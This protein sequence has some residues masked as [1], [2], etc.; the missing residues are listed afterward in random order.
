LGGFDDR[1]SPAYYEDADLAFGARSLGFRVVYQPMCEVIHSEGASHGTDLSGGVKRFQ[2]INRAKFCEK[3]SK[4]LAAEQCSPGQDPVEASDRR[5]HK[6][7]LVVDELVPEPDK[8][9]GSCR[10]RQILDLLTKLGFAVVFLPNNLQSKQPY[11]RDLQERGIEVLHS[12]INI[13]YKLKSLGPHLRMCLLSRPLV[14]WRY[15]H[16]LRVS[17]PRA[18]IV[19]DTVDLHYVREH[20]RALLENDPAVAKVAD[21]F[22][23]L[24]LAL[25]RA[26]DA[27]IA[28]TDTERAIIESEVPGARVFTIPMIHQVVSESPSFHE[29]DGLV[30][31]GNF[32]HLP[33]IDSVE[34]LVHEILPLIHKELPGLVLHLVGSFMPQSVKDL[35]SPSVK[36]AGWIPDLARYLGHRRVF[37]S[38]LRYGAGMK[39]KIGQSM[40]MGLPVVSTVMG[41]E[42]MPVVS[43]EQV[44]VAEGTER[45]AEA[46]VR[47]YRDEALWNAISANGKAYIAQTLSP[48]VV[49]RSVRQLLEALH[50]WPSELVG[51]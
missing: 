44:L 3:W 12:P 21:T 11:T 23:E 37:V 7:I 47:I 36:V 43:G 6:R 5:R 4:T 9:A 8:D 42:G 35:A 39:G 28:V 25:V 14:S 34:Y 18:A 27:T 15:L 13:E 10:M 46:T 45:F 51:D 48:E 30:F 22:R 24:E 26:S 1:Y 32:N 31:V 40:A 19:Y 50:V 17:A 33:N 2:E 41:I 16:P 38:P 49:E 29:R 20:R